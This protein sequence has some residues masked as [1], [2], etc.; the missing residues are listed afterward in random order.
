M[1]IIMNRLFG[2]G[3]NPRLPIMPMSKD[4]GDTIMSHPDIQILLA[5]EKSLT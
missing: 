5:F 3:A 1:K 4:K 2:Y